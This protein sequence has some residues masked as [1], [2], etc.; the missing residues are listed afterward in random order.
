VERE[1]DSSFAPVS[2]IDSIPKDIYTLKDVDKLTKDVNK[3]RIIDIHQ[4]IFKS[5]FTNNNSPSAERSK[6]TRQ[7]VTEGSAQQEVMK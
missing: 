1:R 3:I 4:S 2:P 5:A 7:E 6:E